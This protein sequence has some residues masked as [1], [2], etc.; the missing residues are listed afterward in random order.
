MPISL[1][2]L[3]DPLLDALPH[4]LNLVNGLV[5]AHLAVSLAGLDEMADSLSGPDVVV[6]KHGVLLLILPSQVSN[7]SRG[8]GDDVVSSSDTGNDRHNATEQDVAVACDDGAGH[9]GDEHV[10][11]AWEELLAALF[12]GRERGQ[13]AGKGVFEVQGLVHGAVHAVLSLDGLAVDEEAGGLDML[14]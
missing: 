3:A 4:T 8:D 6:G 9:C 12:R 1:F 10:Y 7:I 13:S 11:G 5:I 2:A 14:C